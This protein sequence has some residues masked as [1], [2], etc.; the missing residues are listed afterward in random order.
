[1]WNWIG[2]PSAK[3]LTQAEA[4]ILGASSDET[5]GVGFEV[6]SP[7]PPNVLSGETGF[8]AA[9]DMLTV[10]KNMGI[11]A[12]PKC[13]LHVHVNVRGNAEG[14][15]LTKRQIAYVW[16][17]Y[18][19]WQFSIHEML[20]PSRV[21]THY[22]KSHFLGENDNKIVFKQLHE[23]LNRGSSWESKPD[24]E[25]CNHVLGPIDPRFHNRPCDYSK[26]LSRYRQLNIHPISKYGTLEF[27][28]HSATYDAE[29]VMRWVQFVVAFVERFGRAGGSTTGMKGFFNT[30]A[31]SDLMKLQKAQQT[32][33]MKELYVQLERGRKGQARKWRQTDFLAYYGHGSSGTRKWEEGDRHCDPGDGE[34]NTVQATCGRAPTPGPTPT[35]GRGCCKW[36]GQCGDC[37]NDGTGWCHKSASNCAACTG[38]SF[39]ANARAPNCGR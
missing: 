29:R 14:A 7:G 22:A 1:L 18:A 31:S 25:F 16:A 34:V 27:R 15:K 5:T 3:P 35:P 39:D 33:T 4:S 28:G 20:S 8:R 38:S 23:W 6:T 19:R 13:G 21:P 30:T 12:G 32:S 36:G 17:A 24:K 9:I 2:D 10:L 11:Q 26:P 37:G